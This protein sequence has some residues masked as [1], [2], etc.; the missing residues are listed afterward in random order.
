MIFKN[1]SYLG[2]K[3]I[4]ESFFPAIIAQER[5]GSMFLTCLEMLLLLAFVWWCFFKVGIVTIRYIY[6]FAIP[7]TSLLLVIFPLTIREHT[8]REKMKEIKKEFGADVAQRTAEFYEHNFVWKQAET[9][10]A[11]VIAYT[12]LRG[13]FE[14]K[15]YFNIFAGTGTGLYTLEKNGFIV[16]TADDFRAFIQEKISEN[17]KQRDSNTGDGTMCE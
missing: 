2:K 10:N 17:K 6:M 1:E 7:F 5:L 9:E 15:N 4:R 11:Q 14:T 8:A 16:G 13:F 12:S 3:A